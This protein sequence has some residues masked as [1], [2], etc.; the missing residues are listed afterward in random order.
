[1]LYYRTIFL[2]SQ[3]PFGT[4][5]LCLLKG[6][7]AG[8]V[9]GLLFKL[10]RRK[11]KYAAVIVASVAAPVC[12]TGIFILGCL[13]MSGTIGAYIASSETLSGMSVMYFLVIA[14]AGALAFTVIYNLTNIN[15][16][17]RIREIAT[18]K[19]LGFNAMET[20]QYV[21]RENMIMTGMGAL[22]GLVLGKLLH[23]YVM[24]QIKVDLMSFDIRI[25]PI[26]YL[27]AIIATF[28]FAIIVA[29]FM[30]F[31]LKKINMAESLKSIE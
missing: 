17:E 29:F 9:P 28:I 23:A 8:L 30:F 4:V 26:S 5:A 15:I 13:M 25:S 18:I 2:F 7:A 6:L 3:N 24:G 10:I 16:T 11:S 27:Y 22:L 20:A 14:C 19:V 12:N 31:K 1:M 21:F